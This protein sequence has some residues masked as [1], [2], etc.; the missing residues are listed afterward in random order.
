MVSN[1]TGPSASLWDMYLPPTEL[2]SEMYLENLSLLI[3]YLIS[4]NFM[5]IIDLLSM[6]INKKHIE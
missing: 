6:S 4:I 2:L 1:P 5:K 3:N